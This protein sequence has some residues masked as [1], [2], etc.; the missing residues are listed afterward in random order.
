MRLADH[1]DGRVI[2]INT[3]HH[4][5]NQETTMKP[6]F[7]AVAAATLMAVAQGAVAQ[8]KIG[9]TVSETG[10]AA[11]LGKV[12]KNTLMLLPKNIGEHSVQYV[13]LDDASDTTIA[14]RNA[15]KL[16]GDDK[17]D[18]IIGSTTTPNSIAITEVAAETGTPLMAMGAGAAIVQPVD[19][20]T[21]WVFK[22]VQNDG[23]MVHAIV[24]HMVKTGMKKIG[25]IGFSDA[26]GEGYWNALV[27]LAEKAGLELVASERY[28]RTDTSVTGQILKLTAAQ[29]NAILIAAS[30]TPAALPQ[31]ALKERGYAGRIYQ[32]H[33][34]ANNDFL[35]VCG[36]D[37]EGTYL[38]VG[39]LLVAEQLPDSPSRRVSMDI[40]ARYEQAYGKGSVTTFISNA[41]DS[42]LL[43]EH[44]IPTALK[45]AKP[46]TRE[47]RQALRDALEAT[48][49][50]SGTQ[51][52]YNMS[53]Q[54]HVGLDDRAR[55][56]VRIQ[57]GAW[58]VDK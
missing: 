48:K 9:I 42:Y 41:Y 17:V 40:S 2:S 37:C 15:R 44:A 6:V 11:S 22:P 47:F 20:K 12:E 30:G 50:F 19:N 18:A 52:V 54:D 43:L 55:V 23:M 31:K 53:A 25:Y 56:I 26:T 35:R 57:N 24:E 28:Q 29:P 33:G 36:K 16:V 46:G 49:D 5:T 38:P 45:S 7:A 14:V 27:P 39:P 8:I 32:T 1:D 3:N 10:P 58:V 21:K 51:G 34:V 4:K 13:M